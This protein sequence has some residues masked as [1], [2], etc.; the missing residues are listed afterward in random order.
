MRSWPALRTA[1][2][3]GAAMAVL[4]LPA[5]CGDGSQRQSR[6]KRVEP[7]ACRSE[8]ASAGEYLAILCEAQDAAEAS[9]SYDAYGFAE[10]LPSTQRAA[11]DA[12]CFIAN[13]VGKG[14]SGKE[15]GGAA[16][17]ARVTRKAEA[18]LKSERNIVAPAP[19]RKAIATLLAVFRPGSLDPASAERYHHACY[20]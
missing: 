1:I 8:A 2:A 11:I 12:F 17:L 13:G 5:G 14:P 15:L 10:Y 6:V 3:I 18:D 19:T 7:A 16:L 9:G 20:R 4:T